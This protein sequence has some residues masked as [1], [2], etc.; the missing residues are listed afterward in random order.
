MR[1]LTVIKQI[2]ISNYLNYTLGMIRNN[3]K[4]NISQFIRIAIREKIDRDF[5]INIKPQN[6]YCPF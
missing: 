5:N 4:I 6:G 3:Y 2:R 1:Q